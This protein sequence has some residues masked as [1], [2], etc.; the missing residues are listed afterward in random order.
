MDTQKNYI[1]I[2]RYE[3]GLMKKKEKEK[4]EIKL[5]ENIKLKKEYE[6]YKE[7]EKD[8]SKDKET[9]KLIEKVINK[10]KKKTK[11]I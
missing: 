3:E 1:S 9:Q 10:R 7:T 8:V 5:T 11:R 2:F 4:F 6:E